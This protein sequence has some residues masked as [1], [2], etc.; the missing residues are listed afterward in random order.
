VKHNTA[1][2]GVGPWGYH[3]SGWGDAWMSTS[4]QCAK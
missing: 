3:P 1:I 4:K 2:R